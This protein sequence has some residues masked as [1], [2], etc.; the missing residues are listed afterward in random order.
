MRK[1]I[2]TLQFL[3][4]GTFAIIAQDTPDFESVGRS[5]YEDS[6]RPLFPWVVA[7]VALV[8]SLMNIGEVWGEHK[9]WKAFLSKLGL[10]VGITLVVILVVEFAAGL[11]IN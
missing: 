3:I 4:L 1:L 9:N 7:I 10:Y 8:G 2:L 11:D 6:V 5:F